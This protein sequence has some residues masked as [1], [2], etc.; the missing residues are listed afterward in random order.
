[1]AIDT[2]QPSLRAVNSH[3]ADTSA[4]RRAA[5]KYAVAAIGT[6]FLVFTVGAA[7]GSRSSLAPLVIGAALMVMIYAGGHL[8]GGHYN[9]AVTIA[10]LVRRRIGLRDAVGYWIAQL[11]AGAVAGLMVRA[12]IDPVQAAVTTTTLAGATLLAAFV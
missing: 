9:P 1:M 10:V 3:V 5:V 6:F 8:S 2:S 12:V 7:V 11:V 4:A